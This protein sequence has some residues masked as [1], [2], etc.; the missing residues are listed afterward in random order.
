[1]V[2]VSPGS[3]TALRAAREPCRGRSRSPAR[4]S[5][6][7]TTVSATSTAIATATAA[8]YP[9][10]ARNGI[11]ATTSPHRAIT[12]VDPGEDD[13]AAGGGQRLGDGLGGLEAAGELAA[14]ARHDEQGVVDPDGQADHQRQRRGRG[15]H[16]G[17]RGDRQHAAHGD[18]HAQERGDDGHA[19]GEQRAERHGQHHQGDEH[20]DPLGR[21]DLHGLV[22]ED[23]TAE[24]DVERRRLGQGP[25]GVLEVVDGRVL[26]PVQR[27]VE[28]HEDQG[29]SAVLG[30]VQLVALLERVGRQLDVVDLAHLRDDLLDLVLVVLT[31]S[32]SG[33]TSRIW[34]DV[35]AASGKRWARTSRP[36]CDSVPGMVRLSWRLPPRP[37]AVA[38]AR[39]SASMARARPA[40]PV[41]P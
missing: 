27:H 28:L 37:T 17:E 19:G 18:G 16:V 2:W 30:E 22:G 26:E 14:V 40:W 8:A 32:P 31:C 6:A 13:R 7:G 38:A 24:V 23:L 25:G 10:T 3:T 9:I 20:A 36:S 41:G 15:V 1:M 12:T 39:R 35:P 5:I 34:P 29:V 11:F 21:R 33:A 4:P